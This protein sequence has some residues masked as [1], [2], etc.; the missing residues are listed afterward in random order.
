MKVEELK[1]G[2]IITVVYGNNV[3]KARVLENYKKANKIHFRLRFP[4]I[5]ALADYDSYAFQLLD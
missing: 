5:K 1:R 4:P 3:H 2:D